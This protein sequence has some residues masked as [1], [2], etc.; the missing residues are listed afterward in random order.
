M[1][2]RRSTVS[3]LLDHYS[4]VLTE[5]QRTVLDLYYNEDFSLSEIAENLG[6]TRQGVRDAILHGEKQLLFLEESLGA[7]GREKSVRDIA[8]EILS[9]EPDDKIKSLAN[10]LLG[11]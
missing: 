10:K 3:F 4:R 2:E 1:D 11:G 9:F 5:R 6:I 8:A 7:A